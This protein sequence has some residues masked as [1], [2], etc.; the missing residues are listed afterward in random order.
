MYV[1]RALLLAC[2][3]SAALTGFLLSAVVAGPA[4]AGDRMVVCD[5]PVSGMIGSDKWLAPHTQFMNEQL[6]AGR[7]NFMP[8]ELQ[9]TL[10]RVCAW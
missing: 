7:T 2:L 10:S 3:L 1:N 6:A 5:E 9:G 8:I 4:Q